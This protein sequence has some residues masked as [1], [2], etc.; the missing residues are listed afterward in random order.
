MKEF[1][2]NTKENIIKNKYHLLVFLLV[3][4]AVVAFSLNMYKTTMGMESIGNGLSEKVVEL[5]SKRTIVQTI[6][7]IDKAKSLSIKF[8][9]YARKNEGTIT[10]D[11]SGADSKKQYA[12]YTINVNAIQDNVFHTIGF[13]E[14]VNANLDKE[15]VIT[16]SSDSLLGKGVGVYYSDTD[17]IEQGRMTINTIEHSG[18]LNC[19]LLIDNEYYTKYSYG[20]IKWAVVGCT[21]LILM[22][23]A[24]VKPE[25]Q[26]ASIVLVIGLLFMAVLTPMSVPDEQYHYE[27]AYQITSKIIGENHKIMDITYRNYSHFN[28]H[29]NSAGAYKRYIEH[30]NDPLEM[31]E[32]YEEII[33]DIDDISY[34]AYFFPQTVGVLIGRVLQQNFLRTF[35]LG[36]LTNLLFFVFC[37]Y[38][39]V[40]TTPVYK[41]LIGLLSCIP[42]FLQQSCSYSYDSF[43]NGLCLMLFSFFL[44][45]Y[46]ENKQISRK[47]IIIVLIIT[48][49]L[50]PAK[51]VY[52]LFIVPFAFIPVEKFGSRKGK[53]IALLTISLPVIYMFIYMLRPQIER[54]FNRIEETYGTSANEPQIKTAGL[55]VSRIDW[56]GDFDPSSFDK[57]PYTVGFIV[58]YP[59]H[60]ILM[61]LKTIRFS[62]KKWFYDSLGRTLSGATMLVPLRIIYLFTI[63]VISAS[64]IKEESHLPLILK[65]TFLTICVII[66]LMIV[67]G[68]LLS[69]TYKNDIMVQG[70]QGR[71]FSPLLPYF[72]SVFN[73][74]YFSIPKKIDKYLIYLQI[75]L[76]FE[77]VLYILSFTFVN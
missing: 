55:G 70:V 26:F 35:F 3:W 24:G 66:A 13:N 47:E 43:V 36:R 65:I 54:L 44:K 76:L 7:T 46:F 9:T 12:K 6:E 50:S 45:W 14:P 32:K 34:L 74:K 18:D 72:F 5:Y 20:V 64:L 15:L 23:V 21:L 33:T 51:F 37:V 29:E 17:V 53:I 49:L 27:C 75:I 8:A 48:S 10:I 39:A 38:I 16:L 63:S 28:G 69:W 57:D 19:K 42:M 56:D 62:L 11:V 67:L 52:G 40:K 4:I 31:K 22:L 25:I 71:Y 30:F 59:I 68:F 61:I 1:L 73:N 60:T 2:K 41:T 58:E 77:I